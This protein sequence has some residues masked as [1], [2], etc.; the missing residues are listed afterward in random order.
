MAMASSR[1]TTAELPRLASTSGLGAR[2]TGET[3]VHSRPRAAMLFLALATSWATLAQDPGVTTSEDVG[4]ARVVVVCA[5]TLP[6]QA[7]FAC[8][9][10]GLLTDDAG[11]AQFAHLLEHMLIR[12]VDPGGLEVDGQAINGETNGSLVRFE[13]IGPPSKLTEMAGRLHRWL[14]ARE[15]SPR[16]LETEK[17]RIQ[18]EEQSTVA[19]GFAAK[20]ASAA[21]SQVVLHGR[22]HAAVHGDVAQASAPALAAYAA[23]RVRLDRPFTILAVGPSRHDEVVG[24][25]RSAFP[26][27]DAQPGRG[28]V[29]AESRT[30]TRPETRPT[31]TA[32]AATWDLDVRH[33]LDWIVVRVGSAADRLAAAAVAQEL[34]RMA[35]MRSRAGNAPMI[36]TSADA[37]A[38][39]RILLA[40]GASYRTDA[41][42]DSIST[43]LASLANALGKVA[44]S[45]LWNGR[46]ELVLKEVAGPD[47]TLAASSTALA[48]MPKR[49]R[50]L[51]GINMALGAMVPYLGVGAT[52]ATRSGVDAA[53]V[54]AAMKAIAADFASAESRGSLTLTPVGK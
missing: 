11:A 21:W 42:G 34:Q 22:S 50:D 14:A 44:K 54:A 36:L 7:L 35:A 17:L 13:V 51:A 53:D 41:E 37:F 31:R 27:A 32:I 45:T 43:R 8:L 39:D 29:D 24:A 40:A 15:F 2:R 26:P 33:R 48:S 10:I 3:L 47:L 28:A 38:P 52:P 4:T 30:A 18:E 19:G 9:P 6:K 49:V 46:A 1:R 20:W 25:I 12:S 23:A 16:V 5:P